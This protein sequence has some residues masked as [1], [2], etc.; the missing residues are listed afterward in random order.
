MSKPTFND[1]YSIMRR[2]NGGEIRSY[3][4]TEEE[5]EEE[6]ART[7]ELLEE[8]AA[9]QRATNALILGLY[10]GRNHNGQA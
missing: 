7:V 3:D 4:L 8:I 10:Q 5:E 9:A 2:Y 1:D 6:D